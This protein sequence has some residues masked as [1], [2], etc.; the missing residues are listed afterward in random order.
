[1]TRNAIRLIHSSVEVTF[2]E[3]ALTVFINPCTI[4]GWRPD[5]VSSQPA[6]FIKNGAATATVEI[7]RNLREL[8]SRPWCNS[9]PPHRANAN[10]AA[11]RY[12]ITRIDQYWMNTS[13]T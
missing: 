7:A 1:M 4:H 9:Q 10:T 5:S 12:A 3:A 8:C 13:G 6:V 11:A 2:G